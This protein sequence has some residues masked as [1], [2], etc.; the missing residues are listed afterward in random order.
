MVEE[1]FLV[2]QGE[3]DGEGA[4]SNVVEMIGVLYNNLQ[5]LGVEE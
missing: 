3:L 5:A 4:R 2:A 1:A